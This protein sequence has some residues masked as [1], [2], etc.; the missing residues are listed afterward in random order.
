M[1]NWASERRLQ[2]VKMSWP[3]YARSSVYSR[4]QATRF[5]HLGM[6]IQLL[7]CC[8]E[9][10]NGAMPIN[11]AS[12]L[13][14]A[15]VCL[16]LGIVADSAQRQRAHASWIIGVPCATPTS[17]SVGVGPTDVSNSV[18]RAES[19]G[20]SEQSERAATWWTQTFKHRS[21]PSRTSSTCA[22]HAYKKSL[23]HI[24]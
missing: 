1:Y 4:G 2:H 11:R 20:W 10:S 12:L 14:Y 9:F 3:P 22:P 5:C 13:W 23:S 21:G 16:S 18:K 7:Q 6:A 19:V 24:L 8:P 15:S 17:L